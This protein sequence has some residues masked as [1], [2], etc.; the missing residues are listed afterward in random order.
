MNNFVVY[1]GFF[2][3]ATKPTPDEI[4][5]AAERQVNITNR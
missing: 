3:T 2:E 4:A 5:R 1:D